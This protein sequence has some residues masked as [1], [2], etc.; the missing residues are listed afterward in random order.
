MKIGLLG[1]T[2]NPPHRGHL[3]LAKA[4][5]TQLELDEI[6]LVPA[7]RN[8]LKVVT[9][10]PVNGQHRLEMARLLIEDEAAM[11][12][13][14]IEITRKGPSYALDTVSEFLHLQPAEYWFLMGADALRDLPKW[15]QPERLVRFCR[16]G[17]FSRPGHD[18]ALVAAQLPEGLRAGID[19]IPCELD[20][21][22]SSDL[23]NRIRENRPTAPLLPE[24]IRKYIEQNKL[25]KD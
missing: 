6:I 17:V 7:Y 15:K 16:L 19:I 24:A 22:S 4:A 12:V 14:D 13:S 10:Q 1:G 2:F 11:S 8:P 23:R 25:Y 18:A 5:Q 3:A 20:T 9:S 21:V